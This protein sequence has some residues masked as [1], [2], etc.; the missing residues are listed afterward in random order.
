MA[1][2][3]RNQSSTKE[4]IIYRAIPLQTGLELTWKKRYGCEVPKPIIHKRDYNIMYYF[5][6]LIFLAFSIPCVF[7]TG[8]L[9]YAINEFSVS[10]YLSLAYGFYFSS[11]LIAAVLIILATFAFKMSRKL[12]EAQFITEKQLDFEIPDRPLRN[13]ELW[14]IRIF[15]SILITLGFWYLWH[16]FALLRNFDKTNHSMFSIVSSIL[17][18]GFLIERI[19]TNILK[20]FSISESAFKFLVMIFKLYTKKPY[21]CVEKILKKKKRIEK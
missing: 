8:I 7:F 12:I 19:M 21:L 9:V 13:Y 5:A 18:V 6:I 1:A 10:E 4:T 16:L 15:R 11:P 2:R 20:R 17:I 14:I 3:Y